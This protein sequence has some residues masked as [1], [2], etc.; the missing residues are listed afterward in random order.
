MFAPSYKEMDI[1]WNDHCRQQGKGFSF[2]S[3]YT[4]LF[5]KEANGGT[6]NLS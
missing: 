5:Y 4:G 3:R 6:D 1:E 2:E